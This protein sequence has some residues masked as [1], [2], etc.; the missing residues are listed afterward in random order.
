MA[1]LSDLLEQLSG[2]NAPLPSV[3]YALSQPT[4]IAPVATPGPVDVSQISGQQNA[5]LTQQLGQ[6]ARPAGGM[7]AAGPLYG[8]MP[9]N[10]K[11]LHN[12][13]AELGPTLKGQVPD[14]IIRSVIDFDSERVST[15]G[16]PLTKDQTLSVF[17]TIVANK[18]ATPEPERNPLSLVQNTIGDLG[19]IVKSIPHLP[20][21]LLHEVQDLPKFGEIVQENIKAGQNPLQAITNA[22]GVRMIPGSYLVGNIGDPAELARHPLFTALDV[23]P[24]AHAAAGAT[25]VG[26]VAE[27]AATAAGRSA[28]PIGAVLTRS[29]AEDGTLMRN[30]LGRATDFLANETRPGRTIQQIWGDQS[31]DVM[32]TFE[33]KGARLKAIRD[34]VVQPSNDIEAF[35]VRA[36]GLRKQYGFDD[37]KVAALTTKAQ[38]SDYAGLAPD[39]LAFLDEARDLGKAY[40]RSRVGA[41]EMGAVVVNGVQEF[42]PK[43]QAEAITSARD[44]AGGTRRI[45]DTKR[46]MLGPSGSINLDAFQRGLQQAAKSTSA[47][48]GN[49]EAQTIIRTMQAYGYDV[50]PFVGK[51]N[52]LSASR[53]A[54]S[55]AEAFEKARA[56]GVFDAT[57]RVIPLNELVAQLKANRKDVLA[58][59]LATALADGNNTGVTKTLDSIMQRVE[60]GRPPVANDPDF[61]RSVRAHRDI[62]QLEGGR[63]ARY[64]DK[65]VSSMATRAERVE[66]RTPPARFGPMIAEGTRKAFGERYTAGVASPEEAAKVTQAVAEAR[67]GSVAP[68]LGLEADDVAKLYKGIEQDVASTWRQMQ[69]KGA[70]P[71][72]VHRVGRSRATTVASPRIGPVPTSISQDMERALD[73]SPGVDD[74]SVA[75]THQGMEILS[76]DATELAIDEV[77]QRYGVR[78]ADIREMYADRARAAAGGSGGPAFEQALRDL[79]DRRFERFNPREKGYSWGGAKLN[80]Y[81]LEDGGENW[82]IPKPIAENLHKMA[83]PKGAISA[84]LDPISKTFRLSVVGLSPRTQLYNILGGATMLFGQTGPGA[85]KFYKRAREWMKDPATMDNEVVRATIGSTERMFEGDEFARVDAGVKYAYGKTLGRWMDEHLSS[86][87]KA[88]GQVRKVVDWMLEKNSMVDDQYRAMAYLYGYDK[89]LTRGLSDDVARRSGETL[90]RKT[91]MDYTGMTPIER[92]VFKSV[93]PFYGFMSHAMRYVTRYPLDHPMRAQ[94]VAAFAQAEQEDLGALPGNFLGMLAAGDPNASNRQ[95]WLKTE[96]LNPFGD[97]ANM[98]TVAGFLSATNPVLNTAFEQAGLT[99]GKAELYPTLRYD[100]ETGRLAAVHGNPLT[101]FLSNTI[102]QTELVTA[103]LGFNGQFADMMQRDPAAANRFLWSSAGMPL[104]HRHYNISAEIAKGEVARQRSADLAKTAAL[105][106]GDWTEAM[107]YPSL[108]GTF[109]QIANIPSET[110]AQFSAPE[111]KAL[112]SYAAQVAGLDG[113]AEAQAG[114]QGSTGPSAMSTTGGI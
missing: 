26:R 113:K 30:K 36:A 9:D 4:Q 7:G 84:A 67:W 29:L 70:N 38:V 94:V 81:S 43:A 101:N 21:A 39:E 2:P 58:D 56:G 77:V 100:P 22:P 60:E 90:M 62:R 35:M 12:K 48:L 6:T 55:Y 25:A 107:R 33:E 65:R 61:I 13:W 32:R 15:G 3:Q 28:R 50:T 53:T 79:V 93:F 108:Q 104:T 16:Q 71:I 23:L 41:G 51:S 86:T 89:A 99:R 46:E 82:F 111:R 34:G 98:F 66:G 74:I 103:L 47:N 44:I 110:L 37:A 27:E 72:F 97:V 14:A 88:T 69:Q 64:T 17:K 87:V 42:Y 75:L 114:P 83:S 92:T 45:V 95:N 78:E 96:S 24:V 19:A 59:R 80:K 54:A 10:I 52:R 18:P 105:E 91:M 1:S 106:S 68:Q 11:K 85:F 40:G 5:Q 57:S 76:R 63:L 112:S 109:E 20:Q 31:R 49:L 8:S 102:P 73:F